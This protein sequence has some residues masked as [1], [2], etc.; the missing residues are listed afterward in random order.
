MRVAGRGWRVAAV[1]EGRAAGRVEVAG[2]RDA[3]VAAVVVLVLPAREAAVPAAVAA[4]AVAAVLTG[5]PGR[6]E[7]PEEEGLVRVP[8]VLA[9]LVPSSPVAETLFRAFPERV[10][11]VTVV[12]APATEAVPTPVDTSPRVPGLI[13]F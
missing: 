3:V 4:P 11:V 5:S 13:S 10:P 8:V 12:P 6:N 7:R 2:R 9:A 1:V